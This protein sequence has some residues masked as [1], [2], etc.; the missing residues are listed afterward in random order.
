MERGIRIIKDILS[1]SIPP[2]H[3]ERVNWDEVLNGFVVFKSN[4]KPLYTEIYKLELNDPEKL[5]FQLPKLYRNFIEEVAEDYVL[6]N[7]SK[8]S[9]ILTQSQDFVKRVHYLKTLRNVIT[10]A[11]R[12]RIKEELPLAYQR[13]TFQPS[14][15]DIENAVKQKAREDLREKIQT[16]NREVKKDVILEKRAEPT[17]EKPAKNKKETKIISLWLKY[18]SVA[19]AIV[20]GFIVWQPHKSSN[21]MIF[22]NYKS[23][24][25]NI[26]DIDQ[27]GGLDVVE[28]NLSLNNNISRDFEPFRPVIKGDTSYTKQQSLAIFKAIEEIKKGEY[29]NAKLV[30]TEI[31]PKEDNRQVLF[32]LALAQLNSNE[33][34]KAIN[35]FNYLT[36]VAYYKF[37]I[38]VQFYLALGYIK[39][40]ELKKAKGIL[41]SK[42]IQTSKFSS[43]A[44]DILGEL[45]W[46]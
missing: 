20:I 2:E 33:V 41:S 29:T 22:N 28:F 34:E 16:W 13:V 40:G 43:E 7:I 42:L 6:G 18:S 38:E 26:K 36:N 17:A 30:L 10:K 35:N 12:N 44:D 21:E 3:L 1:N 11:E 19:A 25:S 14:E 24:L 39:K 23:N 27:F 8:T 31:N 32:Y 15:K 37:E 5:I 9:E 4:Q 46:F 45:R